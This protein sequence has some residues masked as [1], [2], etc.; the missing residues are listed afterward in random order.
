MKC[1]GCNAIID[2]SYVETFA[3]AS[4]VSCPA[5]GFMLEIN[6]SDLMSTASEF[7][8]QRGWTVRL[9]KGQEVHF[10]S[11]EA[12]SNWL[13]H[14][15]VSPG[16][17]ISNS[18]SAWENLGTYL[19]GQRK[20]A[21][22]SGGAVSRGFQVPP[23]TLDAPDPEDE[24]D[25][26][27]EIMDAASDTD[28]PEQVLPPI[29]STKVG[30]ERRLPPP[31]PG[32]SAGAR[33]MPP[34]LPPAAK[35]MVSQPSSSSAPSQT[36]E[37]KAD[38]G[39]DAGQVESPK[40]DSP[41]PSPADEQRAANPA[42]IA[43]KPTLQTRLPRDEKK[44]TGT[45][46]AL[47]ALVFGALVGVVVDRLVR[48][49]PQASNPVA[50]VSKPNAKPTLDL[51]SREVLTV[52]ERWGEYLALP[53][54][55][56]TQLTARL[57]D[58]P[59]VTVE[60]KRVERAYLALA[61]LAD[62]ARNENSMR[63]GALGKAYSKVFSQKNRTL[64]D[65]LLP[66]LKSS[67]AKANMMAKGSQPSSD[68][69]DKPPA[70]PKSPTAAQV[71]EQTPAAKAETARSADKGKTTSPLAKSST[72]ASQ[73]AGAGSLLN[74]GQKALE[75][76]RLAEARAFLAQALAKQPNSHKG[77]MLVG[78]LELN[79]RQYDAA[80]KAFSRARK[81]KPRDRETL[82]GIGSAYEKKGDFESA[83]KTYAT[84]KEIFT[85]PR[86]QQ[87]IEYKLEKLNKK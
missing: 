22:H 46:L 4:S 50:V 59:P 43:P 70:P 63:E 60:G 13:K 80:L 30:H 24:L 47:A 61:F 64:L 23:N 49:V 34:S 17:Q 39:D 16:D 58:K 74:R 82:L 21:S 54:S 26:M 35:A 85:G 32:S 27:T 51:S 20:Q 40:T 19:L 11:E 53:S 41:R 87:R 29:M 69:R 38:Q 12:F 73:G 1:P 62:L 71:A 68:A 10:D 86:D 75:K 77:H 5:C 66:L 37:H 52:G 76:G 14:T 25:E 57:S 36:P 56:P 81:L 65:R 7:R 45:G 42:Y 28:Q 3:K 78:Y 31:V 33:A 55:E 84:Y 9:A 6:G 8:V 67:T 48:E 15:T 2:E 79:Q 83:R 44:S 18:G 72:V